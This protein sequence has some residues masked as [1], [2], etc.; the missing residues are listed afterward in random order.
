MSRSCVAFADD[1]LNPAFRPVFASRARDLVVYGGAG[2]GKSWA[3]AQKLILKCLKYPARRVVVIRKYG[4]SL[5]RTCFEMVRAILR[6]AALLELVKVNLTD[7]SIRF[8]ND[9]EMLFMSIVDSG[10][11]GDP[12]GRIKSLTDITDMWFEEPTELSYREWQQASLRCRGQELKEGYRQRVYSFNPIDKNHWLHTH[13]FDGNR[14]ERLKFTYADNGFIEAEYV[15]ELK[16]LK[17]TD[18]VQY[19][20]YALGEWGVLGNQI[21][22]RYEVHEFEL[23]QDA[24]DHVFCGVDFG[25]ESPSCWVFMGA[26]ERELFVRAEVYERKL[27]NA[28]LIEAIQARAAEL[29][30]NLGRIPIYADSAEPARIAEMAAEGFLVYE[31]DKKVADGIAKCKGFKIVIHPD[32]TNTI[33]EIAGYKWREDRQGNIVD[34]TPAKFND[35]AMDAMRYGVYTYFLGSEGGAVMDEIPPEPDEFD[36]EDSD[37]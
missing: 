36:Q 15:N 30:L 31:A 37:F 12:A 2:A 3:V 35:H 8:P 4:P 19:R 13:F 1:K 23:E 16:A 11:G 18:E 26:R 9:S 32:C 10:T 34:G 5:R 33:K 25:F 22:T 27:T 14:G 28:G 24:I 6:D 17:E 7:M 20:V 29:G 21:Y